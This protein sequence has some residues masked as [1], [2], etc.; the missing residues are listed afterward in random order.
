MR[1]G[2]LLASS[3]AVRGRVCFPVRVRGGA[4]TLILVFVVGL[5]IGVGGIGWFQW[6]R[7]GDWFNVSPLSFPSPSVGS[8]SAKG[9]PRSHT[10]GALDA[11]TADNAGAALVTVERLLRVALRAL[12]VTQDVESARAGLL[13]AQRLTSKLEYQRQADKL[14][15]SIEALPQVQPALPLFELARELTE[16]ARASGFHPASSSGRPANLVM[17]RWLTRHVRIERRPGLDEHV[18]TRD[19]RPPIVWPGLSADAIGY[20]LIGMV[21]AGTIGSVPL[22]R[23]RARVFAELV[24]AD[25][26]SVPVIQRTQASLRWVAALPLEAIEAVR[27][28]MRTASESGGAK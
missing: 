22:Y 10:L 20:H 6:H 5:C 2:Q 28:Q 19:Q 14:Q 12:M 8:A 3:S 13:Q 26:G 16:L 18:S 25:A 9:S 17:P 7:S 27:V 1:V 11:A 24:R 15:H 4:P 21:E 23:Q